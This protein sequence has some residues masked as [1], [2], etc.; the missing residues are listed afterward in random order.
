MTMRKKHKPD[1]SKIAMQKKSTPRF[2]SFTWLTAILFIFIPLCVATPAISSL[3]DSDIPESKKGQE[4]SWFRFAPAED[5]PEDKGVEENE[6]NNPEKISPHVKDVESGT[7]TVE[8]T[9][10]P[11]LP[12]VP[13]IGIEKKLD[14]CGE[15][16]PLASQAIKER[17]ER[18]LLISLGQRHQAVLWLKRSTRYLPIIEQKIKDRN[19]PDDLKY[20]PF[21][22]S[23]MLHNSGSPKGAMGYWQFMA[24]TGREYG[25]V[26]DSYLDERRNIYKSTDAALS[27]LQDLYDM[28]GSWTLAAAAYNVGERRVQKEIEH[29]KVDNYYNLDL[30][31]ETQRYVFRILSAKL[32][33]SDP[34]KYGFQFSAG[35][36]YPPHESDMVKVSC[37]YVFPVH[38]IS[39]AAGVY[40]KQVKD[41]NP[42]IRGRNLKRGTYSIMIPAGSSQKF[43][44]RFPKLINEWVEENRQR[45]YTVKRGDNLTSIAKR[46]NVSLTDIRRWNNINIKKLIHPGDKIVVY[47]KN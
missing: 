40:F 12:L 38:L 23:A 19:M 5:A 26:I 24:A 25:L 29:Q 17:L 7:G 3:T 42:E 21:I 35:D 9:P 30:Y 44:A 45:T 2:L 37:K 41:L 31:E 14:F 43:Y 46:F 20:V 6:K 39:D 47:M 33:L 1:L 28:F 13:S 22:E 36:Y 10:A 15:T 4:S 32:I 34:E 16:V 18:E 11:I 27:Y 8:A